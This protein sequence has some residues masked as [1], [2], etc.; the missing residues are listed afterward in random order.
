MA[1]KIIDRIN[2][3]FSNEEVTFFI[4]SFIRKASKITLEMEIDDYYDMVDL[5]DLKAL[6]II[7]LSKVNDKRCWEARIYAKLNILRIVAIDD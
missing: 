6:M 4:E 2:S 1:L 5:V 7:V 3:G